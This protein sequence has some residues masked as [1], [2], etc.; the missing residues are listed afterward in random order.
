MATFPPFAWEMFNDWYGRVYESKMFVYVACYVSAYRCCYRPISTGTISPNDEGLISIEFYLDNSTIKVF[1]NETLLIS[2]VC[3][4]TNE[5]ALGVYFY[6]DDGEQVIH[7]SEV[8]E[9]GIIYVVE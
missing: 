8:Y 5:D 9:T 3:Y 1:V 4:A 7:N 2:S 6:Y